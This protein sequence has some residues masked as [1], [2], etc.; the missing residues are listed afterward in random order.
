[1]FF[2]TWGARLANAFVTPE[3]HPAAT[4]INLDEIC[5][6]NGLRSVTKFLDGVN[7]SVRVRLQTKA[8]IKSICGECRPEINC[9]HS[10]PHC[11]L[12][13][14]MMYQL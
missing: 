6:L 5:F 4:Y 13:G 3:S 11:Q 2:G 7:L 10:L 1:M 8:A 12:G 9:A 14:M